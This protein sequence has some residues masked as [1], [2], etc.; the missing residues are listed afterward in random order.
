MEPT[1]D[2]HAKTYLIG[3]ITYRLEPLSWQQNKWLGDHI[4]GAIDLAALDYAVIHDLLR[5]KGPLF[6]AICLLAEGETRPAKA[7]L[8]FSAIQRLAQTFAG[9]LTG[10]EVALF[11]PHFFLC[12][13][14]AQMSMLLSG[15]VLLSALQRA[16]DA[17]SPAPIASGSSTASSPLPT[18]TS[19]SSEASSPNT[20]PLIQIRTSGAASSDAPSISPSWDGSALSCPG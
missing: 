13:P 9:E 20:D 4:F 5:E 19:P 14:P 8:P 18:A 2:L 10:G 3:G 11:G 7:A 16:H 6:M 1:T 12:N 15:K 17:P